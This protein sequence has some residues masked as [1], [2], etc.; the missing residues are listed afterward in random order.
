[1][2]IIKKLIEEKHHNHY[3]LIVKTE[4][5]DADD[6]HKIHF[7]FDENDTENLRKHI[8]ACDV[9]AKTFPRGRHSSDDY[10]G[11]YWELLGQDSG[12]HNDNC[13][14]TDT[15]DS[16]LVEYYDDKGNKYECD[17]HYDDEMKNEIKNA[18]PAKGID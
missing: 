3:V 17:I 5:G 13:G 14:F 18:K 9:L 12:W 11:P 2:K 1:M 16:Y 8:I 6:Y 10:S 15:Y 4:T 7:E